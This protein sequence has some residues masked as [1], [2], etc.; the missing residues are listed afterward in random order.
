MIISWWWRL[1]NRY[2][3]NELDALGVALGLMAD[4]APEQTRD[5]QLILLNQK[6]P[7]LS[8]STTRSCA[9]LSA[10]DEQL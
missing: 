6:L 5:L 7:V 8:V 1:E 3:W 10:A 2:N 9:G 4:Y